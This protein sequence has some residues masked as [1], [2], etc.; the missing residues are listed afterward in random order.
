MI[1]KPRKHLLFLASLTLIL[2]ACNETVPY[3]DSEDIPD[4]PISIEPIETCGNGMWDLGEACDGTLG[5]PASCSAWDNSKSWA[6]GGM[7]A[8]SADCKSVLVGSCVE[9]SCGNGVLDEGEVCDGVAGLPTSCE[10]WDSSKSWAD[11]GMPVCAANC[12]SILAGSCSEALC[13]GSACSNEQTC[14]DNACVD[15]N[16]ICG[17][18]LCSTEQAC[19]NNTC[20]DPSLICGDT[21]CQENEECVQN[22]CQPPAPDPVCGNGILEDDEICDLTEGLPATC[23]EWD[24]TQPWRT[25]GSPAC[26]NDCKSIV[27]GSCMRTD[28]RDITIYNYNVLF[29]Y[30]QW[31]N[32]N[33]PFKTSKVIDRATYLYNN[34]KATRD[35]PNDELPAIFAIVETSPQWHDDAV[36]AMF[37]DL[38]YEWADNE[39]YRDVTNYPASNWDSTTLIPG[40]GAFFHTNMLYQKDRFELVE[41]NYVRIAPYY[42]EYSVA[43]T[44]T[45]V[46]AAVL[47]EIET[48]EIFVAFSTH[49]EANNIYAD[50]PTISDTL[51]WVAKHEKDRIQGAK[52]SIKFINEYREKYPNAHLFYGGDFN[53]FDLR[54]IFNNPLTSSILGSNNAELA[55]T[56]NTFING[57]TDQT[58]NPYP[59]L[60]SD[61]VSSH[62]IFRTES[63]LYDARSTAIEQGVAVA[64]VASEHDPNIPSLINDL[65]I[66]VVIDYA[67][68]SPDLNLTRYEVLNSAAYDVIS[69]HYPIKTQYRYRVASATT[70]TPE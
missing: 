57:A 58:G 7:P 19:F 8:C 52:D 2:A 60:G 20:V 64:D 22:Q 25:E 27:I 47:R 55:S 48:N 6:D 11:G 35:D 33:D 39:N 70:S 53:T 24:N 41:H 42:A 38:G 56:I 67:F 40:E 45:I 36:T 10:A 51:G 28:E 16:L 17:S 5:L 30:T 15:P 34:L 4:P 13:G 46:F 61:F 31:M 32:A 26:A 29:E 66:P 14:F 3:S 1:F 63:G 69:D 23:T 68:Y 18:V 9:E 37:N 62:E 43:G 12:K 44:K 54:I 50:N 49:W 65:G 21:I 59:V